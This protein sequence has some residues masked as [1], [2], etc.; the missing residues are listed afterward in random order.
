MQNGWKLMVVL[1]KRKTSIHALKTTR[2]KLGFGT[3]EREETPKLACIF[4]CYKSVKSKKS[5]WITID[6][7]TIDNTIV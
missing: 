4:E 7:Q 6:V 3:S 2:T 5:I 1:Y